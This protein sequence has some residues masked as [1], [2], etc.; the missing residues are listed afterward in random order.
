VSGALEDGIRRWAEGF[1]PAEEPDVRATVAELMA[2]L[3]SGAVRAASVDGRRWTV[4]RWVKE[5]ILLAFRVGVVTR[6]PEAGP[7]AFADKDTLLPR[8]VPP[9]VRVVPGGTAIRAGAHVGAGCVLMPPAYVNVGAFVGEGSLV[10]SH[11]LVGSCAQVGTRVH[12]SA[13]AQIGGV[14]EPVGQLPVIVEDEALVGGNCGLYEGVLVRQRAVIAAG[15]VLT[16]STPVFDA[17]RGTWHRANADGVLEVPHGAVVVMGSRP[18][19]GEHARAA[20]IQV[21]TPVIVKYRDE[22]TDAR[23]ALEDAL[24]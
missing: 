15:V 1:S 14:L 10:D 4:H 12:V 24:R 16:R 20:G 5:G 6:L 11:A 21:A 23:T 17:V 3:E 13:A 22:T 9:N 18:A 2:A 19:G 7:L 8:D